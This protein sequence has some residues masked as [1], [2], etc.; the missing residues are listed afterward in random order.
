MKKISFELRKLFPGRCYIPD[1]NIE[2]FEISDEDADFANKVSLFYALDYSGVCAM[3]YY[4]KIEAQNITHDSSIHPLTKIIQAGMTKER[5]HIP[6]T[7]KGKILVHQDT[8][9]IYYLSVHTN[10]GVIKLEDE[11][12]NEQIRRRYSHFQEFNGSLDTHLFWLLNY[13]INYTSLGTTKQTTV[14]AL[15]CSYCGLHKKGREPLPTVNNWDL[16]SVIPNRRKLVDTVKK[17]LLPL[18]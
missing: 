16:E 18:R 8:T 6:N 10:K 1:P 5:L 12:I 14:I 2:S 9:K 3:I 11:F 17:W 15:I 13:L 7:E 4:S